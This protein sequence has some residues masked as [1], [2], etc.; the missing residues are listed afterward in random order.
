MS[1]GGLLTRGQLLTAAAGGALTCSFL[2]APR[3]SLTRAVA[4]GLVGPAGSE[5]DPDADPDLTPALDRAA[6]GGAPATRG[7][8]VGPLAEPVR[9]M[10][11][12]GPC[13]CTPGELV[14][15]VETDEHVVAFTFDDGP[16]P[17]NT[18]GVMDAFRSRG[19][20]GAATFFWIA[21]NV[22]Q[23][24]DVAR[25]VVDRGYPVGNHSVTHCYSPSR[26]ALEIQP[27]QDVVASVCGYRPLLFRSPGLTRGDVIQCRLAELGMA[28][29]FTDVDLGDWRE[30]RVSASVLVE[31][32]ARTLHPGTIVLLHDG[33]THANT[34]AAVPGMLDVCRS[35]GYEVIW[36]DTLLR[37]GRRRSR[38]ASSPCCV[39]RI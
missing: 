19:L 34:V 6:T 10:W 29:I 25:Q 32:L 15:D 30:P 38:S 9:P 8:S 12:C 18:V 20:E 28:N 24:G 33:G 27:A 39:G 2:T 31:R 7:T 16:W 11:A 4:S 5:P 13:P 37:M 3:W 36:L 26:L 1:P 21:S 23:V 35:R 17:R 14:V 22:R